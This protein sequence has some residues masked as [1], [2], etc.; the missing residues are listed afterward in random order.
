M[1]RKGG[2]SAR[3]RQECKGAWGGFQAEGGRF[4]AEGYG[5][6]DACARCHYICMKSVIFQVEG[7]GFQ[8][9]GGRFHATWHSRTASICLTRIFRI[10]LDTMPITTRG[11]RL[12]VDL[13]L[14]FT[15]SLCLQLL[16]YSW[17]FIVCY[18]QFSF[19]AKSFI[20]GLASFVWAS[21]PYMFSFSFIP[22]FHSGHFTK[23]G[24]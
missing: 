7:G 21:N 6:I 20:P 12:L 13:S 22:S 5:N 1:K 2:E 14:L 8:V 10:F 19:L 3:R 15:Y 23:F 24:M 11:F 4:K 9:E 17:H 18:L 16:M